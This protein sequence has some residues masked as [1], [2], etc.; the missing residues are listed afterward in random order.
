[1]G[2]ALAIFLSLGWT[3]RAPDARSDHLRHIAVKDS[4]V[5]P[6]KWR[7]AAAQN[8]CPLKEP[9]KLRTEAT[10]KRFL[11]LVVREQRNSKLG[12]GKPLGEPVVGGQRLP[13][14]K[15]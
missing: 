8:G 4:P 1:M 6:L 3:K 2:V 11:A 7:L 10:D 13:P 9:G 5:G 15:V 14:R 12:R